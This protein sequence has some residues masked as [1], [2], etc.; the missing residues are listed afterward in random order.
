MPNGSGG[1]R[2]SLKRVLGTPGWDWV[3]DR[4]RAGQWA[5][6]MVTVRRWAP[7]PEAGRPGAVKQVSTCTPHRLKNSGAWSSHG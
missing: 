3:R 4:A 7:I 1:R 6:D 2:A 5:L